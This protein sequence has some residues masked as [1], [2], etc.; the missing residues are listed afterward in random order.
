MTQLKQSEKHLYTQPQVLILTYIA[1]AKIRV[2]AIL[3]QTGL[4]Q[5]NYTIDLT[6]ILENEKILVVTSNT[7]NATSLQVT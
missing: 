3:L 6:Y 5:A 1:G 7:R 4:S 2:S